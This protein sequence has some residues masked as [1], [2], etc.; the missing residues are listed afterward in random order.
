MYALVCIRAANEIFMIFETR[1]GL[2]LLL[3]KRTYK[4]TMLN[5]LLKH[6]HKVN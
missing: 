3:V 2:G 5:G 4:D 1:Q 6:V